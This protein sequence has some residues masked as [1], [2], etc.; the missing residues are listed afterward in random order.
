MPAVTHK[1]DVQA[2]AA[3]GL[4]APGNNGNAHLLVLVSDSNTGAGVP[5]LAQAAFSVVDHFDL[6][7]QSCGFSTGIT[8]FHD[9][10]NGAYQITLAT[11]SAQP[12]AGGCK[13]VAGDY[14]G[15]V[16]VRAPRAQGQA[17]FRLSI[18]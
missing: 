13:W 8:S 10:A 14:L 16:I 2:V 5:S 9:V 18:R 4:A 7:G 3:Q 12:P 6:P 15:R 17:A 1:L 11:H